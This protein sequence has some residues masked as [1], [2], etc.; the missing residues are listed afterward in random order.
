MTQENYILN[1][2]V[3]VFKNTVEHFRIKFVS[4]RANRS[5][6]PMKH[7]FMHQFRHF[8][9]PKLSVSKSFRK[10]WY[11]ETHYVWP[12]IVITRFR[13]VFRHQNFWEIPK[14]P[15]MVLIDRSFRQ[16]LVVASYGL[17]KHLRLTEEQ[18]RFWTASSLFWLLFIDS[19]KRRWSFHECQIF[20]LHIFWQS[21]SFR[22]A[23]FCAASLLKIWIVT[24]ESK[25]R[26]KQQQM[27]HRLLSMLLENFIPFLFPS[28]CSSTVFFV[29]L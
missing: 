6:I 10:F 17:H 20:L 11:C 8:R 24:S 1:H 25:P 2:Y 18:H 29:S 21:G 13:I 5:A 14:G 12:R 26:C 28:F 4:L 9:R 23:Q 22:V 27:F 7:E 3:K 16:F 15:V 19:S